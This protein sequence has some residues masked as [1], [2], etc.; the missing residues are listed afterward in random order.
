[1]A[2]ADPPKPRTWDTGTVRPYRACP[3]N[4][5]EVFLRLG[6]GKAINEELSAN[7]RCIARWIEESGGEELRRERAAITGS[8][9][10]PHLRSKRYVLGLTLTAVSKPRTEQ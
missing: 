10:R 3:P 4:F 5:R 7:Y 6:W 9:L 2:E 8:A 1:M